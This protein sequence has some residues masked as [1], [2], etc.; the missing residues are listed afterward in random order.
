MYSLFHVVSQ[1]IPISATPTPAWAKTVPQA[2]RGSPWARRTVPGFMRLSI[3]PRN[4][5]WL[6]FFRPASGVTLLELLATLAVLMLIMVAIVQFVVEVERTWKSAAADPFAEA[7]TAFETVAQNLASA[8]LE[9]YQDYAD[10]SGAFRTASTAAFVPDHL[11]RRS[12]LDFVCGPCGGAAEF[13][14][15]LRMVIANRCKDHVPESLIRRIA[16]AIDEESRQ[17]DGGR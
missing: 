13:E 5:G 3:Q 12:D 10:H 8:T 4:K 1:T 2:E 7:E 16:E 9:P 14:T 6:S 15:E 17:H 11:A